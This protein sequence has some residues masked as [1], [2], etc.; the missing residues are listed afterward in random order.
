[1]VTIRS[2]QEL[3]SNQQ[4]LESKA[5]TPVILYS[6]SDPEMERRRLL[7]EDG[8]HLFTLGELGEGDLNHLEA[9]EEYGFN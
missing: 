6:K 2:H 9:G 7:A 1:M 3:E 5:H 4:E 8:Q